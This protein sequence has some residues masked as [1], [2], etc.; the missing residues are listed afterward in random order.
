MRNNMKLFI[1]GLIVVSF[2]AGFNSDTPAKLLRNGNLKITTSSEKARQLYLEAVNLSLNPEAITKL[3]EALQIDPDFALAHLEMFMNQQIIG[4]PALAR[5]HREAALRLAGRVSEGEKYLISLIDALNS[6]K[7]HTEYAEKLDKLFPDDK[8]VQMHIGNVLAFYEGTPE[9]AIPH[10]ERTIKADKSFAPVYNSLGAAYQSMNK[11]DEAEKAYKEYIRLLPDEPNP[12]DSYA[13]HLFLTGKYEEAIKQYKKVLEIEPGFTISLTGMGDVYAAMNNMA[14]AE[15]CYKRYAETYADRSSAHESYAAFLLKAGRP[16]DAITEYDKALALDNMN[17]YAQHG[18]ANALILLGKFSKAREFYNSEMKR[19]KDTEDNYNALYMT[20]VSYVFEGDIEA[21]SRTFDRFIDYALSNN[22]LYEA[23]KGESSKGF[24]LAFSGHPDEALK[25]FDKAT[26]YKNRA[27]IT[28]EEKQKADIKIKMDRSEALAFKGE[29]AQAR[30]ELEDISGSPLIQNDGEGKRKFNEAMGILLLKENKPDEAIKLL[31][32]DDKSALNKFYISEALRLKS[33]FDEAAVLREQ[34]L[35]DNSV[36]LD[37]GLIRYNTGKGQT[38]KLRITTSSKEALEYFLKAEKVSNQFDLTEAENLYRK[39]IGLDP[40]FALAHIRLFEISFGRSRYERL[41]P[42]LDKAYSLKDK[43]SSEEENWIT[44]IKLRTDGPASQYREQLKKTDRLF[45]D[46]IRVQYKLGNFYYFDFNDY[47]QAEIH[48]KKALAIDP[49]NPDVYNMIAYCYADMGKTQQ[50]ESAFRKYIKLRPESPDPYDS[51]AE[52]LFKLGKYDESIQ[53]YN[54]ALSVDPHY[55]P[56]ISGLGN[57]YLMKNEYSKARQFYQQH[58]DMSSLPE[59]K[60]A[61]LDYKAISY[62][63][64]GKY[65]DAVST[66]NDYRK[67]AE[68]NGLILNQAKSLYI[69]GMILSEAGEHKKAQEYF[70]KSLSI[71]DNKNLP[72][73]PA[74]QFRIRIMLHKALANINKGDM[75]AV[76]SCLKDADNICRTSSPDVYCENLRRT[77][78]GIVALKENK[79]ADALKYLEKGKDKDLLNTYYTALAYEKNNDPVNAG[80]CYEK[81]TNS[82]VMSYGNGLI[83]SRISNKLITKE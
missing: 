16:E 79:P 49:G 35:N 14:E 50:A 73:D 23:S 12:Y 75:K 81:I 71:L 2:T 6:N 41:R 59:E 10:F 7:K 68:L 17:L 22:D 53:Q 27:D 3:S 63:Y 18:R 72:H 26:E 15:N 34:A 56:S 67:V 39:A 80:K 24:V 52:F 74:V 4:D 1:I 54:K 43:V 28:D 78:S 9:K 32:V 30:K 11:N 70:S 25:C 77:I 82:K 21:A 33:G 42:Y 19:S 44:L 5:E 8:I 31:S 64:E 57:N 60:L 83:K 13:Y 58:Y 55:I 37:I 65:S 51:Y 38:D 76:R 61:A 40:G 36:R 62:L 46:D 45:P 29:T 48:Y 47:A 66:L 69:Q 20:S